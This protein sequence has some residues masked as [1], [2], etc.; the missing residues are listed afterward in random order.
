V[1]H[2]EVTDMEVVASGSVDPRG[3][4]KGCQAGRSGKDRHNARVFEQKWSLP[5]AWCD[6]LL[7]RAVQRCGV[8]PH[9]YG[10]AVLMS[11][12]AFSSPG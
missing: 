4:W 8:T 10:Q 2:H 6:P 12:K 7:N 5:E 11:P 3:E 1:P 9:G